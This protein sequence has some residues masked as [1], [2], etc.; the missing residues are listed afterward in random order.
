MNIFTMD[1]MNIYCSLA[2]PE[3]ALGIHGDNYFEHILIFKTFF[4]HLDSR[5]GPI[6][7]FVIDEKPW[8]PNVT[9]NYMA[10]E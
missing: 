9:P 6:M 10:R 4:I 2:V 5:I 3:R 7:S 8:W 1:S